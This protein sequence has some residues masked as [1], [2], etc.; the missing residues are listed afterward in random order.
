[1]LRSNRISRILMIGTKPL[2]RAQVLKRE[3]TRTCAQSGLRE[4][5]GTPRSP[6]GIN[7]GAGRCYGSRQF[8]NSGLV[9]VF[10]EDEKVADK[11]FV[12]L[13]AGIVR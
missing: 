3:V 2:S 11:C 1:M 6:R 4:A 12:S 13:S 5:A 9:A 7:R 8:I 10:G